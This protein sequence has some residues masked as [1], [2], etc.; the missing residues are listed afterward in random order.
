[1]TFEIREVDFARGLTLGCRPEVEPR[2]RR[3]TRGVV[4]LGCEPE[5]ARFR[6]FIRCRANLAQISQSRPDSGLDLS[7][8]QCESLVKPS[9]LFPLRSDADTLPRRPWSVQGYLAHKKTP[10]PLGSP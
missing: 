8:F 2:V 3:P 1:M 5:P 9:R 10:T 4:F 6:A 7:H